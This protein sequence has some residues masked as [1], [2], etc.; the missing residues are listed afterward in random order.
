MQHDH[1]FSTRDPSAPII[2]PPAVLALTGLSGFAIDRVTG[3]R[4]V[5]PRWLRPIG[6]G[7]VAAGIGMAAWAFLH[8]QQH[9]VSPSPWHRPTGFVTD[10]PYAISRNPMY[11]GSLLTLVGIGLVRGSIPALLGPPAFVTILTRGQIA[12][13]ERALSDA[14][15]SLYE[16]YRG[17]V[18]RWL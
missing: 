12:F 6:F 10:G 17:R 5:L 8:F 11:L 16:E 13:E 14:Y 4:R 7:A 1:R 9:R 2:P 3:N 15:G 18:R